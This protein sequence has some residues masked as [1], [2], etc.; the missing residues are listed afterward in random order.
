MLR[1]FTKHDMDCHCFFIMHPIILQL[2]DQVLFCGRDGKSV[3][4]WSDRWCGYSPL[5][6]AFPSLFS[7]GSS[8]EGMGGDDWSLE[9]SGM[10]GSHFQ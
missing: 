9:A 3:E 10:L 2:L 6:T 4:F 8:K 1:T 5:N 7:L